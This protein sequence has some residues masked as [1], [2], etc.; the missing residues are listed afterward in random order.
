M[1]YY[2]FDKKGNFQGSSWDSQSMGSLLALVICLILLYPAYPYFYLVGLK[3]KTLP[4]L[5]KAVLHLLAFFWIVTLIS[6]IQS[7]LIEEPINPNW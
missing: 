4:F 2:H 5:W 7:F 6:F 1:I 3:D